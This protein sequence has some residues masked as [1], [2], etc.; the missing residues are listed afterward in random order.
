MNTTN[1]KPNYT[2]CSVT[3]FSRI[4]VHIW[5]STYYWSLGVFTKILKNWEMIIGQNGGLK[6]RAHRVVHLTRR[7]FLFFFLTQ[8]I[9]NWKASTPNPSNKLKSSNINTNSNNPRLNQAKP[10]QIQVILNSNPKPQTQP[11]SD[12]PQPKRTQT[13]DHPHHNSKPT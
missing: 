11:N 12:H 6:M 7:V 10:T 2:V 5:Q 13:Q 4:G 1:L 3:I 8:I 9:Q